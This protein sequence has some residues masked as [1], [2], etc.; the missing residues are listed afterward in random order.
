MDDYWLE[1]QKI[2]ALAIMVEVEAMK[3]ANIERQENDYSL[4]Y[5]E[6]E[7]SDKSQELFSIYHDIMVNR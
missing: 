2:Q 7:F 1:A 4:A 6:K 3:V 5:A